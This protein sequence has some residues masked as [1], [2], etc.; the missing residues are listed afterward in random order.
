MDSR[1]SVVSPL[2]L[3]RPAFW[4]QWLAIAE[5]LYRLMQSD[6]CTLSGETVSLRKALAMDGGGEATQSRA[7]LLLERLAAVLLALDPKLQAQSISRLEGNDVPSD[8]HSLTNAA[9]I[10]NALKMAIRETGQA[11][12]SV[13]FAAQRDHLLRLQQAQ[14]HPD[15]CGA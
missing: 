2:L 6:P 5:Q 1:Q 11:E 3:A 13:A 15:S 9:V 12:Y 7:G 8:P 10:S 14:C 4:R